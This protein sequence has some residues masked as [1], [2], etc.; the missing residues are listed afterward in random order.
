LTVIEHPYTG[1]PV[2]ALEEGGV[3]AAEALLISRYFMFLQVYFHD[4]RRIYDIHLAD[5]LSSYLPEGRFP[6]ELD[7]YIQYTDDAIQMGIAEAVGQTGS[8]TELASR[9][10]SRHHYRCA[11]EATPKKREDDIERFSRLAEHVRERF[12]DLVRTDKVGKELSTLEPGDLYIVDDDG[13]ARDIF[14]KSQVVGMLKP[15]WIGR[16]YAQDDVR[17]EVKRACKE[18]D[19]QEGSAS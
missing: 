19:S 1:S 13:E 7:K 10:V 14:E 16:I 3:H 9:L 18:F 5:F 15:I 2:L 12:G 8:L 17:D 4:V 6:V 11:F